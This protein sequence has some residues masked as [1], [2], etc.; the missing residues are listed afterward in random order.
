MNYAKHEKWKMVKFVLSMITII[1]C[2][3]ISYDSYG[4]DDIF[5]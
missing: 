1:H 5:I 2:S 4:C 3:R